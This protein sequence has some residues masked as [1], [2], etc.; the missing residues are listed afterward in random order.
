VHLDHVRDESRRLA[1]EHLKKLTE[2]FSA[3]KK[4][5]PAFADDVLGW[6]SK[7]RLTTD[8]VPYFGT[9]GAHSRYV[10]E[11]FAHHLFDQKDVERVI[12]QMMASLLAD[13]ESLEGAMLVSLRRDLEAFAGERM[14]STFGT[15]DWQAFSD[16]VNVQSEAA[17][18]LRVRDDVVQ[19]LVSMIVADAVARV[20]NRMGVSAAILGGGAATSEMSF[21]TSLVFGLAVDQAVGWAW[22]T[23]AD[24]KGL[25]V[26]RLN[27]R[28][29]ELHMALVAET[30]DANS[31][32][33]RFEDAIQERDRSRR[34]IILNALNGMR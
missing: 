20:A 18:R 5:T 25:L 33:R 28:I 26:K 11:R 4:R 7:W 23:I 30:K 2:F 31:L 29:E 32:R 1:S 34:S 8:H 13:V 21:G 16:S 15:I 19:V 6:Q 12:D 22:N 9:S 24:P 27:E 3:A 10:A 14:Q 17:A